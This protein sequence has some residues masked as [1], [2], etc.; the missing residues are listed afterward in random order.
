MIK[1]MIIILLIVIA[2]QLYAAEPGNLS[3]EYHELI[4]SWLN[5]EIESDHVS[6]EIN[7]LEAELLKKSET[8]ENLYWL[9]RISL[10]QGQIHYENKEKEL[11]LEAL[12][13][14]QK[15]LNQSLAIHEHSDS[16]RIMS[17]VSSLI[18]IQKG[19][20]YIIFNFSKS[21]DQ[22]KASLELDPNN[23]RA[24]LTIAQFLINA[25]GIAGGNLKKGIK[26]LEEQSLR[27][28]LIDEDQFFIFLTLSEA[29]AKKKRN[30]EAAVARQKA[31]DIYPNYKK[32]Q[33]VTIEEG[34]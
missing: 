12:D 13:R 34:E 27:K 7:L 22:A 18:M 31:L 28:D 32:G 9:A 23:T 19:F 21:Q 14:S 15:F 16:W 17:E 2:P 3:G 5:D 25:P 33:T 11:S 20:I 24:S 29:L 6:S 8:W 30:E 10:I 1:K 26:L 4:D